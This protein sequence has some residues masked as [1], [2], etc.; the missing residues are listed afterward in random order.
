[1]RQS[2]SAWMLGIA[3]TMAGQAGAQ[4]VGDYEY[5]VLATSRTS[6][7]EREINQAADE[8]YRFAQVM[9]GETTADS[10]LVA[11]SRNFAGSPRQH[12]ASNHKKATEPSPNHGT[13]RANVDPSDRA[14]IARE[15]HA[16]GGQRSCVS[17]TRHPNSTRPQGT[18]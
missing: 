1:M 12:P 10:E 15:E 9:G 3:L 7:M 11:I 4:P 6:T 17:Q 18:G 5:R 2:V 16:G 14:A 8:G 13:A